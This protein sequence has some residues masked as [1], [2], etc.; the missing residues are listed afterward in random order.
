MREI[1][2]DIEE[3]VGLYQVS[4]LGRVR[5]IE[6]DE[7]GHIHNYI[8]KGKI[9]KPANGKY[10]FVSLCKNGIKKNYR[11]HRLVAETFLPNPNGYK[12]VNHKSEN[13]KDNRVINLEWCDRKYNN[14]YGSRTVRASKKRQK[15]V[16][17]Y[18]ISNGVLIK[19]YDSCKEAAIA[20][21][22]SNTNIS[23]CALGKRTSSYGYKWR[24][25]S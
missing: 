17:Q 5:S 8:R 25:A 2:K 23:A 1:W 16:G 4:N 12:E 19:I 3:F 15:K 18:D 13:T 20:V 7:N 9:L 14:N 24:Y 10:L 22:G 6:R 11:I 21:G